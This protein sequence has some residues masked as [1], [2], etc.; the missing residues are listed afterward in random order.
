MAELEWRDRFSL[1]GPQ[2]D[3]DHILKTDMKYKD[4]IS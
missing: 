1:G 3:E 4:H 2:L